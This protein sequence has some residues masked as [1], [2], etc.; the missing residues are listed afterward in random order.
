MASDDIVGA[1]D[2]FRQAERDSGG[3]LAD[4]PMRAAFA[5][6]LLMSGDVQEALSIMEAISLDMDSPIVV[7]LLRAHAFG[8][9]GEPA[10]AAECSTASLLSNC[11]DLRHL[12]TS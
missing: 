6:C 12:P 5:L 2:L 3:E 10:R 11:R 9:V 7:E 4:P 8:A 1:Q